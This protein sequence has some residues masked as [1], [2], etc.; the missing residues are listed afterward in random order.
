MY[1]QLATSQILGHP[2]PPPFLL[3]VYFLLWDQPQ[4]SAPGSSTGTFKDSNSAQAK[5]LKRVNSAAYLVFSVGSFF[6]KEEFPS[7]HAPHEKNNMGLLGLS[8]CMCVCLFTCFKG[9]HINSMIR[10]F[11]KK[12]IDIWYMGAFRS[13]TAKKPAATRPD[14]MWINVVYPIYR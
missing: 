7:H 14:R 13:Y 5:P 8:G 10:T 1:K 2:L 4:P 12:E 3:L 11:L 6:G 9:F